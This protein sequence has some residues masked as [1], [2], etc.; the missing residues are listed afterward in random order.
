M[1][2]QIFLYIIC[3]SGCMGCAPLQQQYTYTC[4]YNIYI[5]IY[6]ITF[7]Y[8]SVYTT[9]IYIQLVYWHSHYGNHLLTGMPPKAQPKRGRTLSCGCWLT[10]TKRWREK[11][12]VR[13]K[14]V[15]LAGTLLGFVGSFPAFNNQQPDLSISIYLYIYLFFNI[16]HGLFYQ[17]GPLF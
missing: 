1:L 3:N 4:V 9:Y 8:I 2:I 15:R 16:F 6:I 13:I 17:M 10:T 7:K 12:A 14:T 5:Y 11:Q